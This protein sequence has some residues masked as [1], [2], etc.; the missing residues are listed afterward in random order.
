MAADVKGI[1]QKDLLG[2]HI[3]DFEERV[4]I[5]RLRRERI[6]RLQAEIAKLNLGAVLL[7]DPTNIRYATGTRLSENFGLRF[8]ARHALVPVE[9][10]PILF[11]ANELEDVVLGDNIDRRE[12]I[13]IEFWT[14]GNYTRDNI[15]KWAGEL[16][17]RLKE[18]GVAGE[19]VGVDRLD[20]LTMHALEDNGIEL[21]D[22][23]EPLSMAR[24][25]KTVDEIALIKQACAIAD[26]SLWEVQQ[27]IQPGVTEDDMFAVMLYTNLRYGGERIDDKQMTA[28]GNTNPWLKRNAS[29]RII[30]HG[31]LVGMDTDMM[32]PMGYFADISRTYLCGDGKPNEE[33]L[34]AYHRAYDFIQESLPLFKPGISFQEFAEKVPDMPDEYKTNRYPLIS[35]GDGMSD[36]WPGIYFLEDDRPQGGRNYEGVLEENM[37][38]SM[39]A[40]FGREGGREQV[41]LEEQLIVTADG[42]LLISQAP[43]D[44]RLVPY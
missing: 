12:A 9:G 31:D 2:T 32:G 44:E 10:K 18:M 15:K 39:E 14:T 1:H 34:D 28:G 21:D 30:R 24:A 42:P 7:F 19:K 29:D 3:V 23:L 25:I 11:N 5:E 16:K 37:V 36:E 41:K 26:V 4:D 17:D 13:S 35:H 38:M 27:A 43:Y 6:Q 33:Q 20:A 40:S 8:K 22:A